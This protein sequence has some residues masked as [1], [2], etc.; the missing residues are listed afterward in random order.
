MGGRHTV[1]PQPAE[2][3]TAGHLVAAGAQLINELVK[4]LQARA[5]ASEVGEPEPEQLIRRIK[6]LK[7]RIRTLEDCVVFLASAV[8]ACAACLGK[9][10]DCPVCHGRGQPGRLTVDSVAYA[11]VVAPLFEQQPERVKELVTK[12]AWADPAAFSQIAGFDQP[13]DPARP[14]DHDAHFNNTNGEHRRLDMREG[15]RHGH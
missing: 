8:G 2:S 5:T 13:P 4:Q 1:K 10:A 6:R 7:A 14:P 12:Y 15:S 9:M 11:A 3:P